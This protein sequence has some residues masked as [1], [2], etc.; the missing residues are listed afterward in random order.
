[1]TMELATRDVRGIEQPELEAGF[2][3]QRAFLD[4]IAQDPSFR[5]QVA[6]SLKPLHI[7]D[8]ERLDYG[9]TARPLVEVEHILTL[10]N[11]DHLTGPDRTRAAQ[12]TLAGCIEARDDLRVLDDTQRQPSS[13]D[14]L[15]RLPFELQVVAVAKAASG[16]R[17]SA[18]DPIWLA[19]GNKAAKRVEQYFAG[20]LGLSTE[21]ATQARETVVLLNGVQIVSDYLLYSRIGTPVR[22]VSLYPQGL[23]GIE[24]PRVGEYLPFVVE[25]SLRRD[26]HYEFWRAKY[27]Q[28]EDKTQLERDIDRMGVGIETLCDK[29]P[30]NVE[31]WGTYALMQMLT[32]QL[33]T[34]SH[35]GYSGAY[36]QLVSWTLAAEDKEFPKQ[37]EY[38]TELMNGLETCENFSPEGAMLAR[39]S[40]VNRLA[41]TLESEI[42]HGGKQ[43]RD[44]RMRTL[45]K[46]YAQLEAH[47]P[48]LAMQSLCYS[49]LVAPHVRMAAD[50]FGYRFS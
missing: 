19:A 1:M 16:E 32:E 49:P 9:Y 48:R 3:G 5:L 8:Y 13:S 24:A 20:K 29:E 6:E 2:E 44:G 36:D 4:R 35:E 31:F 27:M 46:L 40:F 45:G 30:G 42:V 25:E 18:L 34:R 22:A 14:T 26:N 47:D 7:Q 43:A 15:T 37:Y 12:A 39:A 21:L 33:F 23:V 50:P 10:L 41:R 11:L 17:G 28:P 38:M